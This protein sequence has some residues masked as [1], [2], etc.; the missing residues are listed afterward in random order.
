MTKFWQL[1][2]E[3]AIQH[4]LAADWQTIMAEVRALMNAHMTGREK[5]D[6]ALSALRRMGSE[7]STWLLKVGI[8]VAYSMV[9]RE[10]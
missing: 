3:K 10:Q 6:Y 1:M 9:K 8:E 4:L 2:L 5:A 7:G